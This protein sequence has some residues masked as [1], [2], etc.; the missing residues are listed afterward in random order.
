MKGT[1]T[2]LLVIVAAVTCMAS[3]DITLEVVPVDNSG[4][5]TG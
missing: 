1:I 3:G 5:L 4:E 2:S